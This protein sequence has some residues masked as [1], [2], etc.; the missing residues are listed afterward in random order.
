[1]GGSLSLGSDPPI[2][3]GPCPGLE[4][5]FLTWSCSLAHTMHF[6]L[7]WPCLAQRQLIWEEEGASPRSMHRHLLPVC[8]SAGAT[9]SNQILLATVTC[10]GSLSGD[11]YE[12]GVVT[13]QL[14]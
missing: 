4:G 7:A 5:S 9:H 14:L 6:R 10:L 13:V 11:L 3:L 8:E 2:T 12:I 1:M